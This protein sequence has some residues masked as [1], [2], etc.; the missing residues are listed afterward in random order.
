MFGS[1]GVKSLGE[2]LRTVQFSM[3]NRVDDGSNNEL[4]RTFYRSD[5]R[6][7]PIQRG[8]PD[9]E[10]AMTHCGSLRHTV[11]GRL[12]AFPGRQTFG[13]LAIHK[14]DDYTVWVFITHSFSDRYRTSLSLDNM[15][16]RRGFDFRYTKLIL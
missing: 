15:C 4:I 10:L 9:S 16:E 14:D 5:T 13:S 2:L 3:M 7:R 6:P 11:Y 12:L 1:L 8:R